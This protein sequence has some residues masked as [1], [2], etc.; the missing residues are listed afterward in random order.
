MCRSHVAYT[1]VSAQRSVLG[2]RNETAE[3]QRELGAF[4]REVVGHLVF[5]DRQPR[6]YLHQQATT[7]EKAAKP[8]RKAESTKFCLDPKT[9]ESEGRKS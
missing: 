4:E 1:V 7:S 9:L 5:T 8:N 3:V 6:H 2:A